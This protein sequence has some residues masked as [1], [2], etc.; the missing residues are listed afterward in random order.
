MA[1]DRIDPPASHRSDSLKNSNM[2]REDTNQGG[3]QYFSTLAQICSKGKEGVGTLNLFFLL[4][5][6]SVQIFIH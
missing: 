2:V 3:N 5:L 1:V 4:K 6:H